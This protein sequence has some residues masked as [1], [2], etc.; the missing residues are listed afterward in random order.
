MRTGLGFLKGIPVGD[1]SP[2]WKKIVGGEARL[3]KAQRKLEKIKVFSQNGKIQKP[4]SNRVK[5]EEGRNKKTR[6]RQSLSH[7]KSRNVVKGRKKNEHKSA[8]AEHLPQKREKWKPKE[9]GIPA[10]NHK[11]TNRCV[12]GKSREDER[13]SSFQVGWSG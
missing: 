9:D 4:C 5:R 7:I 6:P 10:S 12:S 13:R 8:V 11:Q 1:K 2:Q 3:L